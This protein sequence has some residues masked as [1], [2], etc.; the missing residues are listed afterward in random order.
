MGRPRIYATA[1]ECTAAWKKRHPEKVREQNRRSIAKWRA[2]HPDEA[3]AHRR[4]ER[5]RGLVSP[6]EY[7]RMVWDQLGLCAICLRVPGGPFHIDHDQATGRVRGLLC[8]SCNIALG[9][10]Q[11]DPERL[12]RA[13]AYVQD[14]ATG[15]P[16]VPT[17]ESPPDIPKEEP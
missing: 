4:A 17:L 2:K 6:E 14:Y 5:S 7:D 8:R 12:R 13:A 9:L 3:A 1:T 10:M 16:G 11:D 15:T